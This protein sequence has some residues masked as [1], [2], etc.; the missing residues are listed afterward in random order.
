MD[1]HHSSLLANSG[2]TSKIT[3][4]KGKTLCRTTWPMAN[5]ARRGSM[6][7]MCTTFP[8][9]EVNVIALSHG[10]RRRL[11]T[12]DPPCYSRLANE[13]PSNGGFRV[14]EAYSLFVRL[15]EVLT[16]PVRLSEAAMERALAALSVSAEKVKR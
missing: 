12:G 5:L 16:Q 3:P 10:A 6:N 4:R 15:G 8:D 2:S 13:T 1:S 11:S 7:E 14:V 9:R